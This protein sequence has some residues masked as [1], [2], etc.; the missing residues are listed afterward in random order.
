MHN[1]LLSRFQMNEAMESRVFVYIN[2]KNNFG[3]ERSGLHSSVDDS[4]LAMFSLQVY[5][6]INS[7][8]C[9]TFK[10]EIGVG[11]L[12]NFKSE[13]KASQGNIHR[14]SII[15]LNISSLKCRQLLHQ[16]WTASP[17]MFMNNFLTWLWKFIPL[18]VFT[19][20]KI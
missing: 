18:N 13:K 20:V 9:I 11:N 4:Y 16:R 19:Q 2:T 1:R 12:L 5:V 3:F 15:N 6:R 14:I 7:K 8:N 10:L 17:E